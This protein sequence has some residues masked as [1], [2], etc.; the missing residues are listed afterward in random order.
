MIIARSKALDAWRQQAAR[1]VHFDSKVADDQLAQLHA[2]GTPSDILEAVNQQYAV[3][4]A[5]QEVSPAARQTIRSNAI[6]AAY[7]G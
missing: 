7:C 1:W 2:P 4:E 6:D 3:H 5:L